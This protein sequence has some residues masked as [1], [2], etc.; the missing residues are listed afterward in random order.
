M[1]G[2]GDG[3]PLDDGTLDGWGGGPGDASILLGQLELP[4]YFGPLWRHFGREI[5]DTFACAVPKRKTP[6]SNVYSVDHM[7]HAEP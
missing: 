2:Q 7:A 4:M 1:V 3:D 6:E 5:R